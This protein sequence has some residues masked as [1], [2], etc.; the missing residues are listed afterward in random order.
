MKAKEEPAQVTDDHAVVG[1]PHH[2]NHRTDHTTPGIPDITATIGG[3]IEVDAAVMLTTNAVKK[4]RN[5]NN[6]SQK[7]RKS[8][9]SKNSNSTLH[10]STL[11]F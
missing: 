4:F 3:G 9:V 11:V 10:P 2:T 1:R 5:N 6:R 8:L 7:N